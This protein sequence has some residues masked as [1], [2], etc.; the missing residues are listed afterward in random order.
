MKK[1]VGIIGA[2]KKASL[3]FSAS[4]EF[5]AVTQ[6]MVDCIGHNG[7]TPIIIP[8][9][10][11]R[12]EIGRCIGMIDGLLLASGEDLSE[13]T[14]SNEV[15]INYDA[16]V[17]G[18]GTKFHRPASMKPNLDK[19]L[20]EIAAYK[21][22]REKGIPVLGI[23]RGMQ[24]MNV[25]EGGT[26]QKE[27]D[28]TAVN[29][30]IDGDGWIH[31]HEVEIDLNTQLGGLIGVSHYMTSSVHHQAIDKLAACFKTVAKA[32]DGII[33]MIEDHSSLVPVWGLQGHP[34][35]IQK[36]FDRYASVFREFCR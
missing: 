35:K 28:D 10:I 31:Y 18:T 29:H 36:N 5:T 21:A 7:G 30:F 32:K 26:L 3:N 9:S 13:I 25:A 20:L 33:E 11:D 34:E 8:P 6:A 17:S 12:N 15:V 4:L 1:I 27:I 23:C 22:A 16:G 19:D 14:Y 24:L 2:H